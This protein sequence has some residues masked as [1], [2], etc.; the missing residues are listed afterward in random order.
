VSLTLLKFISQHLRLVGGSSASSGTAAAAEAAAATGRTSVEHPAA[1]PKPA[2]AAADVFTCTMSGPV[3]HKR[4]L[5]LLPQQ[6][7]Q[8]FSCQVNISHWI[9]GLAYVYKV[10]LTQHQQG[11]SF[12]CRSHASPHGRKLTQALVC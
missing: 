5:Y 8:E 11:H 7:D 12:A 10:A 1:A 3:M 4:L 2:A 6:Y 9:C